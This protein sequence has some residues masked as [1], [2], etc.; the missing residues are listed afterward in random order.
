MKQIKVSIFA[1]I[2]IVMAIAAS[3]FTKVK[4]SNAIHP[5]T[6]TWFRFA[7]SDP[8]DPVQVKNYMNYTW[9]DGQPC[10]GSTNQICAVQVDGIAS[11]GQHPSSV[12]SPT[13]KSELQ[14]VIDDPANSY[15]D[16]TQRVQ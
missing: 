8:T 9:T 7:G 13:L 12:F 2:A 3:A 14:N 15:S 11:S 4:H 1:V 6:L 16:V 5:S 10:S